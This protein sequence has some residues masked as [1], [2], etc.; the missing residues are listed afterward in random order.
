MPITAGQV[1]HGADAEAAEEFGEAL[2]EM[3]RLIQAGAG[4]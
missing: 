1:K 4:A 3:G 2:L